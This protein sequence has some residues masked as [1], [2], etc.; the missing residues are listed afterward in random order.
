M[1]P[2]TEDLRHEKLDSTVDID[3][4]TVKIDGWIGTATQS[5]QLKDGDQNINKISVMVRGKMAQ[6]DILGEM[7]EGRLFSKY[8]IGEVYADFLDQSD[9]E[10]IMTTNRQKIM[11]DD[12]RYIALIDK[13]KND[14]NTIGS[15]WTNLRN[16]EGEKTA[17]KI[18]EIGKWYNELPSDRRAAAKKMFG[19]INQLPIDNE[20]DKRRLFIGGILAFESLKLRDMLDKLERLDVDGLDMLKEIFLQLD[21]LEASSYYQTVKNRLTVIQRLKDVVD[22]D[23]LE[24]VVQQL[25]FDHLWLIDPTWKRIE[26]TERNESLIRTEFD[27]ITAKLTEEEKNGR[28][29]IQYKAMD[30]SHVIIELKRPGVVTETAAVIKQISKYKSAVTK[31]LQQSESESPETVKAVCVLG[32][33]L[34]DWGK[35]DEGRNESIKALSAYSIKILFYEGLISSAERTHAEYLKKQKEVSRV[36]RLITGISVGD[37]EVMNP[38]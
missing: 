17:L 3:G 38:S 24:K 13:I 1:I 34:R 26:G 8:I 33:S 25:I 14:L 12:P 21:D 16:E 31:I 35:N 27:K 6:D 20:D 9:G 28:I 7:S 32:K 18:N 15:K 2:E 30:N 37:K 4:R 11:E 19:K 29:D 36:Y 5:G 10:D 22:D 23:E